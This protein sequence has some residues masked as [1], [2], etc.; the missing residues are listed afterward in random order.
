M[1]P[2]TIRP[3]SPTFVNEKSLFS[4]LTGADSAHAPPEGKVRCCPTA[5]S[6][7]QGGAHPTCGPTRAARLRGAGTETHVPAEGT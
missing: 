2:L 7:L 4:N 3:L 5:P 1:E 6:E